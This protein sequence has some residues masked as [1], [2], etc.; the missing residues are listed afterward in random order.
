MVYTKKTTESWVAMCQD[1]LNPYGELAPRHWRRSVL[2]GRWSLKFMNIKYDFQFADGSAKEYIVDTDRGEDGD[3]GQPKPPNADWTKLEHCQCSN[4]PIPKGQQKYCPAAVDLQ[5]L[6]A[7]F[8]AQPAF[9]K[10]EV[11]VTTQ[12]RVYSKRTGLEEALRS[13]MGLIMATSEC[14]I[15]GE[16]RPMTV[17]H[18][19]FASNDEF[20]M[21]S[22]SVHLV[23]QY[24]QMRAGEK[25]DWELKGLVER[26][27]KLQL[28]NQAMW[29]RIHLACEK[30]ANLKAL[31]TFFSLASSVTF[32]LE[33]QLQKLRH[34][35]ES[36]DFAAPGS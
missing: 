11:S 29:Q 19:P 27:R 6:V 30:D 35:F 21:R 14:P 4:C 1:A 16:L 32:S 33:A 17:H 36:G 2:A 28:V 9:Q 22:V 10:V 5:H 34:S 7:D 24:F 12:E 26:N 25:P 18:M 13:L 3:N 31:L 15:L 23:Q 8:K 20:I